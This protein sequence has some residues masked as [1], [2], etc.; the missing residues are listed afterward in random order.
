[1]IRKDSV[2][3]IAAE[4]LVGDTYVEITFGS[5]GAPAVKDGDTI[6]GAAPVQMAD[7]LN[8]SKQLLDSATTAVEGIGASADNLKSISAKI[9]SGPE[10]WA[11]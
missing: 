6:R 1:M 10:R 3:S 2:A 5:A 11:R 9:N 7:L 8:K 4:G